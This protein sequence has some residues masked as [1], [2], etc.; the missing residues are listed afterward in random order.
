MILRATILH[1][2]SNP[3]RTEGALAC[4]EDGGLLIRDG[5]VASCGDYAAVR[6]LNPEAT[7]RDMR[8]GYLL[9][10]FVDSHIHFPQLRVIG[11]LGRQ[12]LDWLEHQALP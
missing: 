4:H 3:F 2:R 6:Q 12:L 8:G 5:L 11:G 10:G 1:I 7:V 9:P